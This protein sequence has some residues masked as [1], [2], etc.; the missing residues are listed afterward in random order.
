[1][2]KAETLRSILLIE[3]NPDDVE[4][5]RRAFKKAVKMGS[6]SSNAWASTRGPK[7]STALP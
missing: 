6:I 1:M 4:A 2:A 7:T 5:T 3:D